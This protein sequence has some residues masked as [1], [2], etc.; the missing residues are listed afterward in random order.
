VIGAG[1]LRD[2]EEWIPARPPAEWDTE[3]IRLPGSELAATTFTLQHELLAYRRLQ[4]EEK[5]KLIQERLAA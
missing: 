4:R 2:G 1:E 3:T 5:V